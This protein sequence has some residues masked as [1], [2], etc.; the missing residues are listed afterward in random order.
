MTLGRHDLKQ[1]GGGDYLITSD[2][3]ACHL[4]K[5]KRAGHMPASGRPRPAISIT[6]V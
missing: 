5:T 2:A 3:H 4:S 6:V 1:G